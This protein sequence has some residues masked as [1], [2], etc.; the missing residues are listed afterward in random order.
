MT[1]AVCLTASSASAGQ[2]KL[3]HCFAFTSIPEA[4]NADWQAFF[5]ATDQLPSK[6]KSISHVWYG[7]LARPLKQGDVTRDWGVCMEMAD[8]AALTAYD[9]DPAHTAW[10]AVYEKVRKEGTTTFN[11]I[12]Q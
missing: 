3:M 4:T 7:K 9:K 10:V 11:I 1:A 2:K 5:R 12:G 8:E 6:I